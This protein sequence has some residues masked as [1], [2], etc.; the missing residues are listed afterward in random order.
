MRRRARAAARAGRRRRRHHGASSGTAARAPPARDGATT[1]SLGIT[2]AA[3][4][5]SRLPLHPDGP[6]DEERRHRRVPGPPKVAHWLAR[7]P[8]IPQTDATFDRA[9]RP[10][11]LRSGR[12]APVR[13]PSGRSTM[14]TAR[15]RGVD[16]PPGRV[17]HGARTSRRVRRQDPQRLVDVDPRSAP[18]SSSGS[19]T[20][21]AS[22]RGTRLDL[23]ALLS[24]GFSLLFF[25]RGH[26]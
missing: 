26:T 9:T 6:D 19:S 4:S 10:G 15:C 7:Y 1:G 23:L 18:P 17:E 5:R 14:A 25:N 20:G 16:R 21:A 22:C 24:F 3:A 11:P 12:A 2:G 8:P 13:S